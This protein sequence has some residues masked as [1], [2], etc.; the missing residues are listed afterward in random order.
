M[1]NKIFDDFNA[2][3][4]M[5]PADSDEIKKQAYRLRYQVYCIEAGLEDPERYPEGL[6]FDEFDYRSVHYLIRHRKFGINVATT[7]LILPDIDNPEKPFPLEIHSHIENFE[8]L[9]HISRRHLA[10]VSRFCIIKGFR[11]RKNEFKTVTGLNPDFDTENLF[12]QHVRRIPHITLALFACLIKMSYENDIHDWYGVMEPAL[13]RVLSTMGMHAIKLGPI[14]DYHGK[15]QPCTIKIAD[16][17]DS[18][19]KKNTHFWNML[20]NNGQYCKK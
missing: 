20:T 12:T 16:L 5:V 17:L 19:A 9:K 1:N 6:E 15:R 2:Y 13:I 8:A 18:V 14:S 4:D 7:R 10:E 3:F 11:R